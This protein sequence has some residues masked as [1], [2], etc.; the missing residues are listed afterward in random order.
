MSKTVTKIGE[1]SIDDFLDWYMGAK[2]AKR[3]AVLDQIIDAVK[4]TNPALHFGVTIYE[5]E[6]P[7][8]VPGHYDVEVMPLAQRKRID[9]VHFYVYSRPRTEN[10]GQYIDELHRDF[11][12]A[13]VFIGLYNQDRRQA[14]HRPSAS[15]QEEEKVFSHSVQQACSLVR[16]GHAD[17]IEFYPGRF[18][19]ETNLYK[20]DP[21]AAEVA[22]SMRES[23]VSI[24]RACTR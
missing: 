21:R 5:V 20:N 3:T 22:V 24:L 8:V 7:G 10:L 23:A 15:P 12:K 17:G 6:L 19:L 13:K 11:P 14:E 4:T 2:A 1:I 9:V 16:S 18:G